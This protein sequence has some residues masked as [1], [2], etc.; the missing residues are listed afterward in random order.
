MPE[1][2]Y[3]SQYYFNVRAVPDDGSD[4]S[5]VLTEL[6]NDIVLVRI[7][8]NPC[9]YE[10]IENLCVNLKDVSLLSNGS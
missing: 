7:E 8:R 2:T 3:G 5:F 9:N 1:V 10:L 4:P 6:G